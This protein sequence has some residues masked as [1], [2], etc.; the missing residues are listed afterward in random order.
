MKAEGVQTEGRNSE[1][2][3]SKTSALLLSVFRSF[4]L[5]P[6]SLQAYEFR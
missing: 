6:F 1:F 2:D 5:N 4:S 3:I